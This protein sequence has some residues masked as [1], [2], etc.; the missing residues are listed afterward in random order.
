MQQIVPLLVVKDV[1]AAIDDYGRRLG[2]T[3]EFSHPPDKPMFA[4]VKRQMVRIMFEAEASYMSKDGTGFKPRNP[5]GL[6]I[7][8]HLVMADGIDAYYETVM[9]AGA[10]VIRPLF[11][12]EYGMRQFTVRDAAGYL[13]TFIQHMT[14]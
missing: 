9:A 1:L 14:G 5:R 11:T 12:T 6:G 2:F 8:L 10:D 7:E 13:L 3:A 4:T